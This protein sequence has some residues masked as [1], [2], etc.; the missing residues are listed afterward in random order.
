MTDFVGWLPMPDGGAARG[1]ADRRLQRRDDRAAGPVRARCATA[2]SSSATPTTSSPRRLRPGAAGDPRRG[3]RRTSTSPATSPGS[4]RPSWTT[5]RRCGAG[6]AT[7]RTSGSAWSPSA[8]RRRALAA[9]PGRWTRCRWPGGWRRTCGSWSSPARGSTR[10]RCPRR[11]G[12][13]GAVGYVP[14]LY[15]HLA[16]CDVA[17]VQGGLTTT[18]WSYRQPAPVRLRA[19]A[20]PL[21]AELPRA[22]PARPVRRRA[23]A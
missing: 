18:A 14:D 8:A 4:T 9:A 15:R 16:A 3:P 5:G 13:D 23:A 21:R 7:G 6:S 20:A 10:R 2:R 12:V 17:V 19:A 22:P 11:R 1:G